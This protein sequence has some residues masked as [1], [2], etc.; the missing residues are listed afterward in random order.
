MKPYIVA[1]FLAVFFANQCEGAESKLENWYTYW[2]IGAVSPSYPEDLENFLDLLEDFPGVTRI[3]A[4]L[5]LFGFYWPIKDRYL[6]GGVI[7]TFV[8]RFEVD[9]EGLNIVGATYGLSLQYFPQRH[10]GQGFFIRS[11]VGPAVFRVTSDDNTVDETSEWGIGGLVGAG[12]SQP[13]TSGTRLTFQIN[14]AGRRVEGDSVGALN[15]TLGGL[16]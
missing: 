2:G 14:V 9:S 7:N 4:S 15:F 13:I 12:W 1:I 11:D 8:D 10:V 16:F 3:A 5:D 6:L